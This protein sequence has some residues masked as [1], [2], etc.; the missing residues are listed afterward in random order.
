MGGARGDLA[1]G[2]LLAVLGMAVCAEAVRLHVGSAVDPQPGFFPLVGGLLLIALSTL[3]IGLA[4]RTVKPDA[5]ANAG[6]LAPPATL[7][8]GMVVYVWL[9]PWIGYPVATILLAVLT[10]RVQATRW[11]FAIAAALLLSLGSYFLFARLGVPLPGGRLF[12]G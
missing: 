6:R 9:L 5:D 8:V 7:V 10:L 12:G 1:I 3:Q 4:L 11:R 2:G